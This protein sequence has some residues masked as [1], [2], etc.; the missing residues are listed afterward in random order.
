LVLVMEAAMPKHRNGPQ[1]TEMDRK[2]PKW[3]EMGLKLITEWDK[4]F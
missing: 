2:G 4:S 1:R 3:T